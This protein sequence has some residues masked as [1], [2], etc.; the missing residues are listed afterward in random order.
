[1]LIFKE[2]KKVVFSFT[3]IL[4][5]GVTLAFYI[6][7]FQ[8]DTGS[9]IKK[10]VEGRD[11]Y[12]MTETDDPDIIM[13]QAIARLTNETDRNLYIAYPIGFYKEVTLNSKKQEKMK[14]ILAE[15]QEQYRKGQLSY[16]TF[17]EEM[18][19]ADKL[20][21]GGS[22]YG[23]SFLLSNFGTVPAAYE[24]ALKEYETF[25][26]EDK[27]T[28]AYARLFCDYLGIVLGIM[29]VF[30][31]ASL[32]ERDKKS[33]MEQLIYSR[34][35]SSQ[36][37]VVRRFLALVTVMAVPVLLLAVLATVHV[38]ALYPGMEMRYAAIVNMA[39]VWLLPNILVSTGIGMAV[40]E[41]Y[42]SLLAIFVQGIWWIYSI[43]TGKLTGGI[44]K[45]TLVI[46]HNNLY[47]QQ[48]FMR[49][50]ENF[51]FSRLFYLVL[52]L[53]LVVI[54]VWIY[55]KKRRG[56]FHGNIRFQKNRVRKSEASV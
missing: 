41:C 25:V 43:S 54:T 46:R 34:K 42:S 44:H 20:I 47:K 10:P 15:L 48:I 11:D 8:S 31:A 29:P 12:G 6:T 3:Y 26:S 16:D 1:M 30:V 37:L 7:Q 52:S 35:I 36:G 32:T 18:D 17:L 14:E 56:G 45:F 19:K 2:M 24:D 39:V 33:G 23:S 4:F 38:A 50:T 9:P 51:I 5:L 21:G 40:T 27:V 53:I 22:S 13:Q 49:Q 55:E 28:G